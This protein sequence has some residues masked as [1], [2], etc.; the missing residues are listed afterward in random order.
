MKKKL[1]PLLLVQAALAFGL[2][3]AFG[4]SVWDDV[5]A[6]S[7]STPADAPYGYISSIASP[8]ADM[9]WVTYGRYTVNNVAR[10][11]SIFFTADNWQTASI[12]GPQFVTSLSNRM[13]DNS[14]SDLSALNGQTAWVV[15]TSVIV[16]GGAPVPTMWKTTTGVQGFTTLSTALPAQFKRIHF[17][18]AT[19]GVALCNAATGTT[20]WQIYRT[21]DAGLT[22]VPLTTTPTLLSGAGGGLG[23]K[24]T[25]PAAPNSLWVATFEGMLH[26]TDAGLTWSALP[27]L[28]GV[29]FKDAANGLAYQGN[30]GSSQQLLLTTDGGTTWTTVAM[31]TL[32]TMNT[33]AAV[34]GT[35]GTYISGGYIRAT[36]NGLLNVTSQTAITRDNGATWQMISAGHI[37]FNKIIAN[38]PTQIWAAAGYSGN[39]LDYPQR[40]F[41]RFS[42]TVLGTRQP[43]DPALQAAAYPNPTSGL[44]HLTGPMQ[45]QETVRVY[46]AAG[47]Q[48]YSSQVSETQRMVDLSAQPAG[49]YQVLLTSASGSV[50]SLKVSK[51]E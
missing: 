42:S 7:V 34:P 44:L 15:G 39:P 45:G 43:Q 2:S 24:S 17:F 33:L 18:T 47:R 29:A 35:S 13:D 46:D 25:V 30:S 20:A 6:L 10:D 12:G 5:P 21:T 40:L 23:E 9:G 28:K 48:C 36:T 38:S 1:L 32:P 8:Q 41:Q 37:V 27:N 49:L 31:N 19:T 26:T 14:F 3:P 50:R 4:Q 51:G 16:A 11:P 22:W